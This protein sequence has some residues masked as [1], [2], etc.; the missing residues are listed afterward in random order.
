MRRTPSQRRW[1]HVQ[2]YLVG[3]AIVLAGL[4]LAVGPIAL[5]PIELPHSLPAGVLVVIVGL[6][7]ILRH[8]LQQQ[9]E[10]HELQAGRAER[11]LA[12]QERERKEREPGG[13]TDNSR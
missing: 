13:G 8:V 10:A 1:D 11:E 3:L 12:A 2:G 9:R 4:A 5:G 6:L 7:W